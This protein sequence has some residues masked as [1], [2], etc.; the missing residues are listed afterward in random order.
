MYTI[1]SYPVA[2]ALCVVTMLCWGSWANTQ[3]LASK[4][5]GFP[6]FYWDYTLGVILLSL[7]FGLT[8]GSSGASG[9]PFLANLSHASGDAVGLALIG[10]A[11]FNI[12]NL[13]LVAAIEIAGMAIAFP[14][15]IGIAL[16]LGVLVN[17]LGAP[18]G[19]PLLLFMGVALVAA[20]IVLDA[21]AYRR[22]STG[23]ATTKGIVISLAAGVLM[24][25]FYRFVA[26]S[27]SE[28][29]AN[30]VPGLLTPYTAVFVF[31]I[32]VFASNFVFNSFFM[33]RPVSGTRVTYRDYF[34][35]GTPR[36]HVIG[37]L[38]GV[39]WCIGMLLNMIASGKAGFAISYGLGQGATMIA[40][41]WGVF[42]WREFK[43]APKGT[44]TL[45]VLMFL[46]FIAGLG[47][48]IAARFA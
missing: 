27:M 38:G 6:L 26:A 39:I 17:Y 8:L 10:G 32:G 13:L 47:L 18:V 30:P 9:E 2:V 15:G 28:D 22:I 5:W 23:A 40:A 12:A 42:V 43:Q 3:K 34:K 45:I 46:S 36:L 33:Y 29:F 14:I 44:N 24:G 31:S 35:L 7:I 21:L 20:A 37:I 48:I 41:I 25:F 16:A 1:D 11:V 19:N 4:S